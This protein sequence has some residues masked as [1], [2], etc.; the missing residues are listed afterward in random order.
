MQERSSSDPEA[1]AYSNFA[2]AQTWISRAR[3]VG[4]TPHPVTYIKPPHNGK[5]VYHRFADQYT[6]LALWT[7]DQIGIERAVYLDGD[8]LVRQRFDELFALPFRFAAVPDVEAK[9]P[10]FSLGFNAGVLALRPS[11]AVFE[12]LLAQI[13]V[14]RFPL[15]MAEQAYL[16]YYFGAEAVRLPHVYNANLAIKM[17]SPRLWDFMRRSDAI[18]VVHYTT[19]KPFDVNPRLEGESTG[20]ASAEALLR[21]ARERMW[22]M[23]EA[24]RSHGGIY[25]EEI[26]WWEDVWLE[27]EQGRRDEFERCVRER[28][29]RS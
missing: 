1:R 17:R 20:M 6:K 25:E 22:V 19:P 26:G 18:R 29:S 14:A 7:L 5:D 10:G 27:M 21:D 4:W 8:T 3:A 15:R 13:D 16:N 11:T 2:L 28:E 23:G 12:S 9:N 24:K